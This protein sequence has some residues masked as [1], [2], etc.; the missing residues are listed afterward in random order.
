M[1][2]TVLNVNGPSIAAGLATGL[3]HHAQLHHWV[4]K[5]I[6][7]HALPIEAIKQKL[8]R[9]A[10]ARRFGPTRRSRVL[11]FDLEDHAM[12]SAD[13]GL[14]RDRMIPSV[15]GVLA[16][17]LPVWFAARDTDY[18]HL[19][20]V[21]G[22]TNGVRCQR[23][24]IPAWQSLQAAIAEVERHYDFIVVACS[25]GSGLPV[26][27]AVAAADQCVLTVQPQHNAARKL[28]TA[29]EDLWK[30]QQETQT[31]APLIGIVMC[32][33]GDG[34][35]SPVEARV[36]CRYRRKMLKT[37]IN[38]DGDIDTSPASPFVT[39]GDEI[40]TQ[41]ASLSLRRFLRTYLDGHVG[42]DPRL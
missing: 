13:L 40:V 37:Q 4:E 12:P 39:L 29:I 23:V 10:V 5:R 30:A 36:R 42:P 35:C 21:P 24:G 26:A 41:A 6:D 7:Q 14:C 34:P 18:K 32:R 27:N 15:S 1:I 33:D 25:E 20:I 11:L 28:A 38:T 31:G 17:R 3:V 16:D 19:Q 8:R 9:H 22:V 2:I